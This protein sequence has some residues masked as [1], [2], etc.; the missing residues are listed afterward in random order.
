MRIVIDVQKSFGVEHVAAKIRNE[1]RIYDR[2]PV[3]INGITTRVP[4]KWRFVDLETG[5]VWKWNVRRK[6]F[7][8]DMYAEVQR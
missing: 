4:S 3:E 5:D 2:K 8:K 7:E 1:R 6:T